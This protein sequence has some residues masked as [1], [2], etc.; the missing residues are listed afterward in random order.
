MGFDA[1]AS[2]L[3]YG[4]G[5]L[6]T[7]VDALVGEM[8][9]VRQAQDIEYIHRMRVASRRLR[10]ALVLFGPNLPKKKLAGWQKPIL[11]IT[12]SLGAARDLDVQIDLVEK[13]FQSLAS[14]FY[15]PGIQRIILRLKQ[16]RIG[17]QAKVI[18][19]V[20]ALQSTPTLAG[21]RKKLTPYLEEN[22]QNP[23]FSPG[24]YHLA[25]SSI[26][27]RLDAFL[28]YEQ[29]IE[30]PE[31]ITELHAMRIAAKHLRYTL[32]VFAPIYGEALMDILLTM[33][34]IQEG[35]GEI[36]DSDVWVANLP[37]FFKK[38]RERIIEYYGNGRLINRLTP[39]FEYFLQ[40]RQENREKAYREFISLWKIL[41]TTETWTQL[42]KTIESPGS[43]IFLPS[44]P[45][46]Q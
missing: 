31:C 26:L 28:G 17:L 6:M 10:N 15:K 21:M 42:R 5:V 1:D 2:I 35:L 44:D 23:S 38:E 7:Q 32:E 43:F 41:K 40:N 20:Q 16:R 19:S 30:K 37:V 3:A 29:F 25:F 45:E 22:D 11:K 34:K 24:L 18:E 9:G 33:R 12:K 39:G 14:P 4:A 46:N 27:S 13:V 8:D 36:H